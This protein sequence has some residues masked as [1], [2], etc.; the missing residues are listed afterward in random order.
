MPMS[1][2]QKKELIHK[3]NTLNSASRFRDELR[4]AAESEGIAEPDTSEAFVDWLF[5]DIQESIKQNSPVRATG[6][7]RDVCRTVETLYTAPTI[8][9][10]MTA[11]RNSGC[12]LKDPE[13]RA[14]MPSENMWDFIDEV[15]DGVAK[16]Y[17]AY[18][19]GQQKL[20]GVIVDVY[21][22]EL[23]YDQQA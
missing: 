15:L 9:D 16:P 10:A 7:I 21:S 14:T 13:N 23:A 5:N 2:D 3:W 20:I 11:I 17:L 12:T 18:S 8:R 1:R 4:V 22:R 19:Q 6:K